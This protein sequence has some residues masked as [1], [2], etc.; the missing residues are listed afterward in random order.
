MVS[1]SGSI[2]GSP[3]GSA[4]PDGIVRTRIRPD[5]RAKRLFVIGALGLAIAVV[6]VVL[7][8]WGG[9]RDSAPTPSVN[10][11]ASASV[12]LASAAPVRSARGP[13][14]DVRSPSAQKEEGQSDAEDDGEREG[15]PDTA[16]SARE[17]IYAFPPPG[18]KRIKVG[19]V[20]PDDFELPPGYVRHYQATDKGEM[21]APILMFHPLT[22]P[23]DAQGNPVDVP[24]DRVV[25]ADMAPPGLP[26]EM[27]RVPENAY[28]DPKDPGNPPA[29]VNH[30]GAADSD[31]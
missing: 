7:F 27:L 16:P 5:R 10:N 23:L 3:S 4:D 28:A 18:T 8:R 15:A 1:R 13:T 24:A 26:I 20:V 21:L 25:P 14:V 9:R 11:H 19:L 17:G 6:S 22:P 2:S 30:Q 31:P 29:D 12:A